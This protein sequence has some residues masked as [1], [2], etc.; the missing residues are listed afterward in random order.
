MYSCAILCIKVLTFVQRIAQIL[1]M[2]RSLF[3]PIKKDLSKKMVILTGPRQIGKTWLAKE[4]MEGFKNAQYL[5]YDHFDD[6]RIIRSHAWIINANM[7]VLDE[8]H[9]M[10]GWKMFVKGVYDTL[11]AVQALLITGSAR[12]ETFRQAGGSL[13]GRYFHFRLNPL[14]VKELAGTMPSYEALSALNTFGGFP[15][16]FFIRFG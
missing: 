15:R 2:K 7:L 10:K 11:P 9:K 8:I 13:A 1:L 5:N 6:A 4:L 3:N 12:L 16:A 14:S